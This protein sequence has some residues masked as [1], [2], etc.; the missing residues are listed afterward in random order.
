MLRT[1][2]TGCLRLAHRCSKSQSSQPDRRPLCAV[3][4]A[5]SR[6]FTRDGLAG[7]PACRRDQAI[8]YAEGR[9]CVRKPLAAQ[10]A[11][12]HS[13]RCTFHRRACCYTLDIY[14]LIQ[15]S[16]AGTLFCFL[17]EQS[18]HRRICQSTSRKSATLSRRQSHRPRKLRAGK[19]GRELMN[20]LQRQSSSR[21]A[22]RSSVRAAFQQIHPVLRR[23]REFR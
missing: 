10:L 22:A 17:L 12:S 18:C 13:E 9:S 6:A 3:G 1:I 15:T 4:H 5:C 20:L 7:A 19:H 11:V 2:A 16:P 21:A 8:K 14:P 23:Y